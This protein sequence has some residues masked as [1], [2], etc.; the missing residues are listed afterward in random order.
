MKR[1]LR[2]IAW[3]LALLML[4]ALLS[5]CKWIEEISSRFDTASDR[6]GIPEDGSADYVRLDVGDYTYS[7][8]YAPVDARHSYQTLSEGQRELYDALMECVWDVDSAADGS[9]LYKTKQAIVEGRVLSSVEIRLV[10]KAIYDDHP[11]LFWLSGTIYQMT[12]EE[13]NYTAVQM[14][15]VFSPDV[16]GAMQAE[17]SEA[18]NAFYASA[19]AGMDA[20]ECE[21]YVH[22]YIN[23]LCEYD[24]VAAQAQTESEKINEAYT[25]YGTM[26]LGKSVCEGYARS[27]QLL[28]CGLGVDCVGITGMGIDD[29]GSE[30]LHMWNAV[31]LDG[32]WYYVDPTWDD[33]SNAFRRYRYF[34]LDADT[35]G[36]DHVNSPTPDELSEEAL[37][38]GESFSAVALNLFIPDCY[39]DDYCYYLYECPHLVDYGGATVKDGLYRSAQ[40]RSEYFTF[41]IDPA[42][43]DYSYSIQVL[44][45]ESPQYFF[46][47]IGEVNNWLSDCEID[48]SNLTYIGDEERSVVT[49]EM[50][51]Y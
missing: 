11:D 7:P 18:I 14:R 41:Y 50:H 19:P 40:E 45:R 13:N 35:M 39:S 43:L 36:Q 26:V 48:N 10:A 31:D 12:D 27:M 22:D 47:Y 49:V 34:N 21:K 1:I 44:F 46:S 51:Y 16:I 15:S 9:N 30:E 33:Q 37:N 20:Y 8:Y 17:L 25:I 23:D 3:I 6:R 4:A 24:S 42:Q 32:D 2:I 28:L 29:D 38:G 5:S